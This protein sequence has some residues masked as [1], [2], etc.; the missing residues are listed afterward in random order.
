MEEVDPPISN[1]TPNQAKTWPKLGE[2]IQQKCPELARAIQKETRP[3]F[4]PTK[5][6]NKNR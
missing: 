6:P 1:H 2:R 5:L 4:P 3:P